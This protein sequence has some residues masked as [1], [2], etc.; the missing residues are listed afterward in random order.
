MCEVT[1][2]PVIEENIPVEL[3]DLPL[4]VQVAF[5]VYS[6][7][8]DNWDMV[9][10]NYLGKVKHNFTETLNLLGIDSSDY[11]EMFTY[12]NLIDRIRSELIK[13]E[14]Q[15]KEAHSK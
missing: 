9:G 12:I 11:K 6:Q 1:G 3:E 15:Q 14:Q 8:Q 10:G 2:E 13:L 4:V 7:L 5:N